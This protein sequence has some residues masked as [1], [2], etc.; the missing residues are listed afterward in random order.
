[1]KF[2]YLIALAACLTSCGALVEGEQVRDP[3]T[4]ALIDNDSVKADQK[5]VDTIFS[6]F[7]RLIEK[8]DPIDVI[9]DPV[10]LD[11]VK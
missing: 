1:M 4:G 2:I 10:I 7:K 6:K 5:T 8:E 9:L 3:I 11:P